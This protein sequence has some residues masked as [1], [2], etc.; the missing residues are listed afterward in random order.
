M[1]SATSHIELEFFT[2]F[3]EYVQISKLTDFGVPEGAVALHGL[4]DRVSCIFVF[5]I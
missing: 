5:F 2:K 1:S 4:A 3:L